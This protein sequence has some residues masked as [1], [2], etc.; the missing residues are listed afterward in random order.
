MVHRYSSIIVDEESYAIDLL[1]DALNVVNKE[2]EV[3]RCFTTWTKALEGLRS[4]KSDLI[5]LDISIQGR[6]SMDMLKC[7][8]DL[9]SEIIFVSAYPDY[10]LPAFQFAPSGYLLKPIDD[11]ALANAVD[12][13]LTR[14][15]FKRSFTQVDPQLQNKIGIPDNNAIHYVAMTDIIYLEAFNTYTRVITNKETIL[16]SYNI[17][18]FRDLLPDNVFLALHRSYIVNLNR[19]RKYDT[20]GLVMMENGQT[21]PV[22][23]NCRE[24]LLK[25]FVRVKSRHH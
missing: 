14:I 19:I 16:S 22:S 12:K 7:L 8:P 24:Q 11:I 6:N 3:V 10:A 5:F 18:K 17:G 23:R 2:I 25:L 9:Q 20:A 21:I 4:L 1:K 13:A 15:K